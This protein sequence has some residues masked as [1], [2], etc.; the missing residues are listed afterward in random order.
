MFGGHDYNLFNIDQRLKKLSQTVGGGDDEDT[1]VI[2]PP[3]QTA[4][5][6]VSDLNSFAGG[7]IKHTAQSVSNN[8][9]GGN[10]EL[11][12]YTEVP[13][14]QWHTIPLGQYIRYIRNDGT[15]IRG[16]ILIEHVAREKNRGFRIQF[17]AVKNKTF[18]AYHDTI[19]TVYRKTPERVAPANQVASTYHTPA[20]VERRVG[21]T[22]MQVPPPD[23]AISHVGDRILFGNQQEAVEERIARLEKTVAQLKR[24]IQ[25]IYNKI[26]TR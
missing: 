12:G 25:M 6:M 15:L 26:T 1:I 24:I 19:K 16:G 3:G 17:I 20:A 18:V 23:N 5:S 10:K 7:A 14:G 22:V 13:R 11:I 2:R 21:G 4:G 9:V 8:S